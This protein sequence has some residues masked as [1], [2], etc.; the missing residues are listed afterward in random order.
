[1]TSRRVVISAWVGV[2]SPP[3]PIFTLLVVFCNPISVYLFPSSSESFFLFHSS[4]LIISFSQFEDVPHARMFFF[5]LFSLFLSPFQSFI[6]YLA[7]IRG[8]RLSTVTC[9]KCGKDREFL[10]RP[11]GKWNEGRKEKRESW[12]RDYGREGKTE[13]WREIKT[14]VQCHWYSRLHT[15]WPIVCVCVFLWG[16]GL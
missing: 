11:I 16:G 6:L 14:A 13:I 5:F 7:M 2:S 8:S 15:L 12:R 1:M 3:S 9:E 4:D 10:K